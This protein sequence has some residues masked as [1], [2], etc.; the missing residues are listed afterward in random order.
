MPTYF[1]LVRVTLAYPNTT[2]TDT[3]ISLGCMRLLQSVIS[4]QLLYLLSQL[5]PKETLYVIQTTV[6]VTYVIVILAPML[7][8]KVNWRDLLV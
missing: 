1:D 8:T 6:N 4:R 2:V 7:G 5:E 3:V